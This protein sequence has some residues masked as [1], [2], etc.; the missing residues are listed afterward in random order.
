[1]NQEITTNKS[2]ECF[3]N[4]RYIQNITYHAPAL[5]LSIHKLLMIIKA[6]ISQ[7]SYSNS[8]KPKYICS[9]RT[10]LIILLTNAHNFFS[11][12]AFHVIFSWASLLNLATGGILWLHIL[13]VRSKP[14]P[15]NSMNVNCNCQNT[16]EE[17]LDVDN[18]CHSD[19]L[20]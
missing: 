6:F 7:S 15:K 2:S 19:L 16:G 10:S 17:I 12:Y 20:W 9:W 4:F 5:F 14:C 8:S 3:Y 1:M 11:Y 13:R 18:D